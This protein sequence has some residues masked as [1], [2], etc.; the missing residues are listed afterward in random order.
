MK[1]FLIYSF[2]G[3]IVSALALNVMGDQITKKGEI[4]GRQNREVG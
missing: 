1:R 4:H 2:T 3:L